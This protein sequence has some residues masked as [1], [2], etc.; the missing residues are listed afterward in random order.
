MESFIVM[1]YNK[2]CSQLENKRKIVFN[3]LGME[4]G[5][6]IARWCGWIR[7]YKKTHPDYTINISTRTNRSDLYYGMFDNIYTY[8]IDGDYIKFR[9]N[10]YR[11]DF[12]PDEE[13]DK[14]INKISRTFEDFYICNPPIHTNNRNIFPKDKMDFNFTPHPNNIKIIK[15]ILSKNIKKIPICISPRHRLDSQKPTRNWLETYWNDL[16]A[17]V[18]KTNKFIVFI[19]G[20]RSSMITPLKSKNFIVICD[21]KIPNTSNIGLTIE[22]IKNSI[23]TIGQQ[24]ALP[25]LSNYLKTPTIM[26][27]HEKKRHQKL[28]NPLN[29]RCVFFEE[30]SIH[31]NTNPNLIFEAILKES[32]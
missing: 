17:K 31:Y 3:S 5:W 21:I 12:W 32:V 15:E 2:F 27:G 9:P 23:L 16:F 4:I 7:W 14:L 19:L 30:L 26:W 28:E 6:E 20:D 10:M 13:Q 18:D 11:L 22:A 8:N 29:T 25:V 24:S 1:N